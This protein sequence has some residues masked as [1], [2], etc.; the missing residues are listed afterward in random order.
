MSVFIVINI[1]WSLTL[2]TVVFTNEALGYEANTQ[3]WRH[4][5]DVVTEE[6]TPRNTT[7]TLTDPPLTHCKFTHMSHVCF[8]HLQLSVSMFYTVIAL[9]ECIVWAF[10]KCRSVFCVLGWIYVCLTS[11]SGVRGLTAFKQDSLKIIYA[12]WSC[13]LSLCGWFTIRN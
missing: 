2:F 1:H 8:T 13:Y 9:R 11:V 12:R 7:H 3:R 5:A 6:W 4:K 10:L